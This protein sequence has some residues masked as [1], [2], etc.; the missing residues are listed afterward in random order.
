M[1]DRDTTI[2][3]VQTSDL[4]QDVRCIITE[5]QRYAYQAV[6][7]GISGSVVSTDL[8]R[9]VGRAIFADDDFDGPGTPLAQDAVERP[10]DGLLLIVG[11]D[12]DGYLVFQYHS[13]MISLSA[14]ANGPSCRSSLSTTAM[15][16][17][18]F[19]QEA[20][21][22]SEPFDVMWWWHRLMRNRS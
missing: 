16:R 4:F 1:L 8:L 14:K 11:A 21:L 3:Y 19:K 22:P 5:S 20:N 6:N 9:L 13:V 10:C 7:V 2:Q 18:G 17:C 12:N 15:P